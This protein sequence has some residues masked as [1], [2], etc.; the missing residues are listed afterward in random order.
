M[1]E[2]NS[3]KV[4]KAARETMKKLTNEEYDNESERYKDRKSKKYTTGP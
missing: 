2:K 4:K 1:A 3:N